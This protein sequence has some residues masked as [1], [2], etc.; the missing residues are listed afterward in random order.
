MTAVVED[1]HI[2]RLGL[3]NEVL[4]VFLHVDAGWLLLAWISVDEN[5][6]V[7]LGE[8]VVCCQ[9]FVDRGDIVD[10]PTKRCFGSCM[11]NNSLLFRIPQR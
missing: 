11:N 1:E 5:A 2:S 7:L 4:E 6:D 9:N 10:A 3:S 8:A